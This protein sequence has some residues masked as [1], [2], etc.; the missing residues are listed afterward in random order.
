MPAPARGRGGRWI[1]P[2]Q[3]PRA[4][5]KRAPAAPDEFSR[6]HAPDYRPRTLLRQGDPTKRGRRGSGERPSPQAGRT[7]PS[8]REPACCPLPGQSVTA[9]DGWGTASRASTPVWLQKGTLIDIGRPS[10]A[11]PVTPPGIRVPYHGGSEEL[12]VRRIG[13]SGEAERIKVGSGQRLL[14]DHMARHRPE[15]RGRASGHRR[16]HMRNA[17]LPQIGK[18]GR[19][20]SPLP[21]DHHAESPANP[22][23]QVAKHPRVLAETKIASPAEQIRLQGADHPLD[24]DPARPARQLSHSRLEPVHRLERWRR[25]R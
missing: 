1:G 3:N 18:S 4:T 10:R 21:P 17:P 19:P 8:P 20:G 7:A 16:S 15:A 6:F 14:D 23:V 22:R 12:C 5:A 9:G 11:F 25:D 13:D 2:R 24:T